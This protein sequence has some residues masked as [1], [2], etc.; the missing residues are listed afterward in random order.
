MSIAFTTRGGQSGAA[1]KAIINNVSGMTMGQ[2]DVWA[3][4]A[5]TESLSTAVKAQLPEVGFN[6]KS[7]MGSVVDSINDGSF[8][9]RLSQMAQEVRNMNGFETFS[10]SLEQGDAARQK[11]ATIDL[12]ARANRQWAGAEALY[13]TVVVGYKEEGISLPIDVA[14]VGAY[15]TSGNMNESWEDLRPIASVLADS[16]FNPGDDLKLV[17]V[18]PED[19]KNANAAAFVDPTVWTPWDVVYDTNDLLRREAHKTNYLKPSKIQ[20][21][22]NLCRAPGATPFEQNDEIESNSIRLEDVLVTLKTAGGEDVLNLHTGNM[23]G[24]TMRPSNSTTSDEKRQMSFIITGENIKNFLD[25]DEKPTELFKGLTDLGYSVHL[26]FDIVATYQRA[27]KAWTPTISGVSIS[28]LISKDGEKVIPGTP[29][30]PEAT[31]ALIDALK[32]EGDIT[33]LHMTMNHNNVNRSRYGT[34]VVYGTVNKFYN[35]QRRTPISVKYPMNDQDNNADILARLVK[36]MNTMVTRNMTH[37]A[38]KAANKHFDYVYANHGAKIVNINDDSSAVMPG[39]HFLTTTGIKGS[40]DL[41]KEVSTLDSKDTRENISEAL[42]SKLW[43]V[44]TAMRVSSNTAALKELDGRDESYTVVAHSSLAPFL[45]TQ[46]DYRTFG[47]NIKFNIV[48]TNVD[49]EIGRMWV[50]PTSLTTDNEI[51]LFGGIGICVAKD[52]L[53]VEG[54]VQQSDRQYRMIITQPA[55]QHHS[56]CPVIGLVEVADMDKLLGDEGLITAVNKHLA[57]I[58]GSI[59]TTGTGTGTTTGKEL[60]IVKV[61]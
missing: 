3:G 36:D 40:M 51:D 47:A 4:I 52:L 37:D 50:V 31:Q 5:G 14:G 19:P 30:M 41:I 54:Q 46:G 1:L 58:S 9:Q 49:S 21:L 24:N 12:N 28:Y 45:L 44:I 53:V 33:G 57:K 61:P 16:K 48:E 11:A 34:T 22:L 26:G 8:N 23:S 42:V 38:F 56:L 18:L 35:V 55:Y 39:Q 7:A 32:F 20:N 17:P 27:T 15:N 60:P 13:K 25:K 29:G 59:E 10:H 6:Q 2:D 43:D